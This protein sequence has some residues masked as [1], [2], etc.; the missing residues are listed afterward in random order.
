MLNAMCAEDNALYL[1]GSSTCAGFAALPD[2]KI[3]RTFKGTRLNVKSKTANKIASCLNR[4]WDPSTVES[5]TNQKFE[6]ASGQ[7]QPIK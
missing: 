7:I 2:G 4:I 6:L 3:C 1:D 5:R